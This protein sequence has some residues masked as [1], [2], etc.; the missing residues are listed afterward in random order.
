[1]LNEWN[2][3][4]AVSSHIV[5]PSVGAL[6]H[7]FHGQYLYGQSFIIA[8]KQLWSKGCQYIILW[9]QVKIFQYIMQKNVQP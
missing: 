8:L 3:R 2:A 6:L 1:M 9:L 4:R 5:A 7:E